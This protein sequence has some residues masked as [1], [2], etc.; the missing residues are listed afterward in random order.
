MVGNDGEFLPSH[1]PISLSSKPAQSL[2]CDKRETVVEGARGAH[3]TSIF[4][5]IKLISCYLF[6]FITPAKWLKTFN[7]LAVT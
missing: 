2:F 3:S 4:K 6:V 7:S 1:L 5:E